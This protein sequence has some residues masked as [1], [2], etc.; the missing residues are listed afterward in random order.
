MTSVVRTLS[1]GTVAMVAVRNGEWSALVLFDASDT[2]SFPLT[3][4]FL[5]FFPLPFKN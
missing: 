3:P 2:S 4:R 5:P 1:L